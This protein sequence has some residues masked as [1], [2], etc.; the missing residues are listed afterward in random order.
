MIRFPRAVPLAALA[1]A[2]LVSAACKSKPPVETAPTPTTAPNADS[3]ARENAR[4][5]S[6]AAE[7]R[8]RQ[9]EARRI[10]ARNDSI[11]MANEAMERA[12]ASLSNELTMA[13]HFNFDQSDILDQDRAQLDRKAAILQANPGVRIRVA[14]HADERGSDEYNMALGQRRAASAK[15]YLE[16]RGVAADRI[17][18]VSFGE[19]K[20]LCE[21]H[22]EGCWAQNRRGEFE[23]LTGGTNLVVPR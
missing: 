19:E 2:V 7:E 12:R 21:S 6:I 10:Q 22:D 20:P 5:D 8:R 14:G 16:S 3:I 1:S 13:V 4:R 18:I 11:R 9:D 17:D 23:I 15:R